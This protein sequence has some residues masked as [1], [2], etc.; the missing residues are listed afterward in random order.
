MPIID[1]MKAADR[2]RGGMAL[3]GIGTGCFELQKDG[4]FHK[5]TIANNLPQFGG[6]RMEQRGFDPQSFLFFIVRWQEVGCLPRLK[7]LQIESSSQAE[8]ASM[9]SMIYMYPWMSGVARIDYEASFPFTRLKFSDP[10]MPFIVEMEAWSSFIPH[11][12]K[13][14][15]LPLA[16]FDFRVISKTAKPVDVMLLASL[17]NLVGFDVEE[18]IWATSVEKNENV[19]TL[20]MTAEMDESHPSFGT[21]AL[22]SLSADSTYHAGWEHIHPYYEKLVRLSAFEDIDDTDGRNWAPTGKPRRAMARCWSSVARSQKLKGKGAAF[23]HSFVVAWNFP[24]HYSHPR[25]LKTPLNVG[26]YYSN[27]FADAAAVVSHFIIGRRSLEARTRGFHDDFYASTLPGFLLD[28]IN[29]HLNTLV[30]STWLSKAGDFAVLEGT[31]HHGSDVGGMGGIAS[32]DVALYG[33]VLPAALF[34]QLDQT[35][36]RMHALMQQPNGAINHTL[37]N[38]GMKEP[39]EPEGGLYDRVDLPADLVLLVL[40]NYFWTGDLEY[41]REMWP[42]VKKALEYVLANRDQNGDLL[43]DMQGIMC[44]YDNFPMYGLAAYVGTMFLAG[45]ALAA[46]AAKA[47]GDDAAAQRYAGIRASATAAIEDKLWNGQYYRLC[48]DEGGINGGLDEGCLVD[49]LIGQWPLRQVGLGSLLDPRHVRT[50]LKSILRMNSTDW[51]LRNCAWPGDNWLHDFPDNIWVDHGNTV[52]TGVELTFAS[53]LIHE[54]LIREGLAIVRNVDSRYRKSGL[55]FDHQECGGHYLRPMVAWDLLNALLGLSIRAG[56]FE[57]V[58]KLKDKQFKI[59]FAFA[60]GWAFY[61]QET[62]GKARRVTI[63]V[64][65]G[66]LVCDELDFVMQTGRKAKVAVTINGK[67][68]R[69]I[70]CAVSVETDRLVLRFTEPLHLSSGKKIEVQLG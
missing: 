25:S 67:K 59:I 1:S 16:A 29:S 57:F 2:P 20:Q 55:Y 36:W 7:L 37:H 9:E 13:N 17:R 42:A 4:T 28:Q 8:I 22:A 66:E 69:A 34:P 60:G 62:R 49:Q 43:P 46:E 11:D 61:H 33:A 53:L 38:F 15:A 12:V 45:V 54:G 10:E 26:H 44:S 56:R 30:T 23:N 3:G 50:A 65:S 35:T 5:W 52:W 6:R 24:N 58:P 48:N 19:V 51:G 31:S 40:R 41:L 63:E 39:A 70:Q 32:I 27:F 68:A 64:R 14:S 21:I 47:V 18:K